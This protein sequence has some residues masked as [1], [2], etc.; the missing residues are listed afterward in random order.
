MRLNF[1][2]DIQF[3]ACGNYD[4]QF[5]FQN[6][7]ENFREGGGATITHLRDPSRMGQYLPVDIQGG[8]DEHRFGFR[9]HIKFDEKHHHQ[10]SCIIYG[11][12]DPCGELNDDT[13][14]YFT[15]IAGFVTRSVTILDGEGT[16][17]RNRYDLILIPR[18]AAQGVREYTSDLKSI[19][20]RLNAD[21]VFKNFMRR[22]DDGAPTHNLTGTFNSAFRVVSV[23]ELDLAT[24]ASDLDHAITE[25]VNTQC[26]S[27][28]EEAERFASMAS[29]V[30]RVYLENTRFY[31][32][33]NATTN[34]VQDGYVTYSQLRTLATAESTVT[35]V[36]ESKGGRGSNNHQVA[37]ERIFN[38]H[39]RIA[40]VKMSDLGFERMSAKWTNTNGT[41][42]ES[43]KSSQ[44]IFNDA[45]WKP[46]VSH[47]DERDSEVFPLGALVGGNLPQEKVAD[48][49]SY[50][51]VSEFSV[52]IDFDLAGDIVG[53]VSI[54][55]GAVQHFV[56]PAFA[57]VLGS[58]LVVSQLEF[59]H[60]CT[61]VKR[62]VESK[63]HLH[64]DV[65]VE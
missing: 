2:A 28:N 56:K 17:A 8:W 12:T 16:V 42:V 7:T 53:K 4:K 41:T 39:L 19:F 6:I 51:D 59:D 9:M 10:D 44:A 15:R 47:E 43:V 23:C 26:D 13:K 3:T 65:R 27:F 34:F 48:D 52:E 37:A 63:I 57:V 40:M 58:G 29:I 31:E 33:L 55:G 50:Y 1:N 54:N 49:R 22:R 24:C 38:D 60:I 62:I 61:A 20:N 18:T 30:S 21:A 32:V 14:I 45:A 35:V 11:Y 64:G 5:T 46:V 25:V 36:Y